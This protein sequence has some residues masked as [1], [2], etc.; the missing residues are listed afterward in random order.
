MVIKNNFCLRKSFFPS[1]I[2]NFPTGNELK[3]VRLFLNSRSRWGRF[4]VQWAQEL[5][6]TSSRSRGRG[7]RALSALVWRW[8]QTWAGHEAAGPWDKMQGSI[9]DSVAHELGCLE[10]ITYH[11][12]ISVFSYLKTVCW[13]KCLCKVSFGAKMI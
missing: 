9:P 8:A 13:N 2:L 3:E 6:Y 7:T 5:N 1:W 11:L 4:P 12:G 10:Q